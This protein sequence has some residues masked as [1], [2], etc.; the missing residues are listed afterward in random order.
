MSNNRRLTCWDWL[1][2]VGA[3]GGGIGDGIGGFIYGQI[4]SNKIRPYLSVAI[5]KEK[6]KNITHGKWG[7]K[8]CGEWVSSRY[9]GCLFL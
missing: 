6:L 2:V 1:H 4:I 5:E 9:R 3:N 8:W 7:G